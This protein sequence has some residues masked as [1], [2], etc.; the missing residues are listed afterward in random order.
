MENNIIDFPVQ[1]EKLKVSENKVFEGSKYKQGVDVK[2]IA[3]LV[4]KDIKNLIEKKIIPTG[5]YSVKIDRYAGGRSL[6]VTINEFDATVYSTEAETHFLNQGTW[7]NFNQSNGLSAQTYSATALKTL[8]EIENV[9]KSYTRDASDSQ[10]DYFNVN[11][12]SNVSF[13]DCRDAEV[14]NLKSIFNSKGE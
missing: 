13:G 3:K 4:R 5:K 14:K 7:D 9:L 6:D 8:E 1:T 12:Y 11:F 2:D 10:V